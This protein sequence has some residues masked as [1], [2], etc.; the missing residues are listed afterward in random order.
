MRTGV[1][2]ITF[3]VTHFTVA[4][5]VAWV[6]TGSLV[7]GGLIALIEPAINTVAYVVHERIWERISLPKINPV[8]I[9]LEA[10]GAPQ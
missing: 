9:V 1:K 10:Y 6:L 5:S 4:F 3:A 7:I 2:T 8:K